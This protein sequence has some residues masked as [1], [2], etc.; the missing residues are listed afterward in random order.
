MTP[1]AQQPS[2]ALSSSAK[3]FLSELLLAGT[4]PPLSRERFLELPKQ[5]KGKEAALDSCGRGLRYPVPQLLPC[6]DI[7]SRHGQSGSGAQ[8]P[9]AGPC[10]LETGN[11][12]EAYFYS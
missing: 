11:S 5:G 3:W 7:S 9:P 1:Q 10:S 8:M 2:P 6:R 12:E 4:G